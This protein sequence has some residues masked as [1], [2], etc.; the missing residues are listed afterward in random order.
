MEG[1]GGEGEAARVYR[2]VCINK[3]AWKG[4]SGRGGGEEK[5]GGGGCRGRNGEVHGVLSE[6]CEKLFF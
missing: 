6:V 4:A 2:L 3:A 5:D 1:G